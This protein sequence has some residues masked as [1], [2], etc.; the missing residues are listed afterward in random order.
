MNRASRIRGSLLGGAV[1]DA[2]GA[3]VEFM[4]LA[5][6][7]DRY[8]PDGIQDL[9]EAYGRVGAITDDTQMALFTAEGLLRAI[10]RFSDR[11][12]CNVPNV[13]HGAYLRWL[14]TQG[15]ASASA[16]SLGRD[17]GRPD[18]WL[19]HVPE[20]HARRAPGSTCLTA[21][22]G[23]RAGS[24]RFPINNSKGCGGVMRVAPVGL[25]RHADPFA[26]G[27]EVAAIT[28][29]H[30][31]GYL[32]AGA[33]ALMVARIMEGASLRGAVDSALARLDAEEGHEESSRAIR[34]AVE[35]SSYPPSAETVESLGQGWVAE[36][37]LSIAV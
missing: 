27:C 20:L 26:L 28:H 37:A 10:N 6:I 8:G 22:K 32:T 13:I 5:Q 17:G 15:D 35:A 12:I 21:L 7:R 11:G 2:L 1:G 18:G 31:S 4:S 16:R 23:D 30:P 25:V 24:P 9:D 14:H 29:G 19:A 3:P 34:A 33:L 36:E